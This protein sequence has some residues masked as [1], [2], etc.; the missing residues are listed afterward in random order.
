VSIISLLTNDD[1]TN[2]A[3]TI[4]TVS[5][6]SMTYSEKVY[7]YLNVDHATLPDSRI[8]GANITFRVDKAWLASNNISKNAVVLIRYSSNWTQLKTTLLREDDS[9]VYYI[10][11]S[12][13]LSLFA[14]SAQKPEV[15]PVAVIV[16]TNTTA[17]VTSA[18]SELL[19]KKPHN[20]FWV[21]LLSAIVF[22][23]L[24]LFVMVQ[25]NDKINPPI[26]P[27]DRT[28]FGRIKRLFK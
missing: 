25:R 1:V 5:K 2:V 20:W 11:E 7:K 27:E 10:A 9:T 21:I 14:I 3:V 24:V 16:N 26:F 13:G 28:A 17:N 8:D 12:P 23:I 19:S 18:A 6:P 4:T 22:V 15:A